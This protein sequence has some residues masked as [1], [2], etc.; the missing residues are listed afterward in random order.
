V[1]PVSFTIKTILY[2]TDWASLVA[3]MVKNPLAMQES[4][5]QSLNRED[6]P[7]EGNDNPLQY[8]CNGQRNPMDRGA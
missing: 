7:G 6:P 8:S 4:L 1:F 2:C 3:Q 5:V